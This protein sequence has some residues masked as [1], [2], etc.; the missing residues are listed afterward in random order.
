MKDSSNN[1]IGEFTAILKAR[2]FVKATGIDEIPI[3]LEK[4]LKKAGVEL[5][6]NQNLKD[7]EAGRVIPLPDRTIIE[8]NGNQTL[9]RQR[10]TVLHEIGHIIL[11]LPSIHSTMTTTDSLYKY[12]ARPPE[13]I[14]CD[15]FA[16]EC[17]FPNQYFKPDVNNTDPC[18][19][20][21]RE[22]AETYQASLTS[23][24][25][26]YAVNTDELCA[27]VL[28]ENNVIRYVS[29]SRELREKGFWIP[30]GSEIPKCSLLGKILSGQSNDTFAEIP[31]YNW[32]NKDNFM[33]LSLCEES[34]V[35]EVWNQ[36]LT[37]LWF[38]EDVPCQQTTSRRYDE[39]D[40]LLP[41]LDGHLPWPGRKK[42]K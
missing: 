21:V 32:T 24:V 19:D 8:I 27:S 40:E 16:A 37:L 22:L 2:E 20:A 23:T 6:V 26:R 7:T 15:V 10:F 9:E 36:A 12:S 18:M 29:M 3:E 31:A 28:S 5:S 13:E 35:L 4:Y 14:L 25:S 1:E 39:D 34:I 17:L 38:E 42:R 30:L 41:E 11:E 33:G